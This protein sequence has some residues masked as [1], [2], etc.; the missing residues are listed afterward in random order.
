MQ[1]IP[2]RIV[3]VAQ[4]VGILIDW[5]VQTSVNIWAL[6][7]IK[8]VCSKDA[9]GNVCLRKYPFAKVPVYIWSNTDR[10]SH[11]LLAL[12]RKVSK[13]AQFSGAW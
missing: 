13:Q 2:P 11:S 6:G 12:L 7:N 9:V 8:G 1:K 10:F 5:I 3:F 4:I